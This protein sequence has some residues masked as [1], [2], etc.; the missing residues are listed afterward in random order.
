MFGIG[1][2]KIELGPNDY[3]CKAHFFIKKH[4]AVLKLK[5]DYLEI[6]F[7]E[8]ALNDNVKRYNYKNITEISTLGKSILFSDTGKPAEDIVIKDS[9]KRKEVFDILTNK[10]NESGK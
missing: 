10:I 7:V 5:E 8:K 9:S 2:K 3:E 4:K 6:E 1:E